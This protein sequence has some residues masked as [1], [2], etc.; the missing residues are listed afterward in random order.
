MQPPHCTLLSR[1]LGIWI[2]Y[3][4]QDL[5]KIEDDNDDEEDST[6]PQDDEDDRD[7][8]ISVEEEDVMDEDVEM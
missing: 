7:S 4:P 2:Q 3:V 5:C 8:N 1:G 6:S